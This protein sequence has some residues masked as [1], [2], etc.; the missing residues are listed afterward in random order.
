MRAIRFQRAP[1]AL[2]IAVT[3]HQSRASA[4]RRAV[5]PERS[6]AIH[7]RRAPS[8]LQM[9]DIRFQ[10]APGAL[11]IRNTRDRDRITRFWR[12]ATALQISLTR[13]RFRVS[14][15]PRAVIALQPPVIQL[16]RALGALQ[17][18]EARQRRPEAAA[19]QFP[20]GRLSAAGALI[21]SE[22]RGSHRGRRRPDQRSRSF[23]RSW[24]E[25]RMGFV[26]LKRRW[27]RRHPGGLGRLEA[28]RQ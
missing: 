1:S 5:V 9:R 14:G 8:A 3:S 28:S 25:G 21:W 4:Q 17:M 6:P 7:N 19:R 11:Q 27:E 18:R 15:V 2:Q 10:R 16:W 20:M 24:E 26:E 23:W 12:A 13:H 22:D